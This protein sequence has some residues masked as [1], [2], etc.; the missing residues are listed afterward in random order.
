MYYLETNALYQLHSQITANPEKIEVCCTSLLAIEEILAGIT[1]EE[2]CRRKTIA[3]NIAR[4]GI[5]I[6]W[7]TPREIITR[8]FEIVDID[9]SKYRALIQQVYS[10]IGKSSSYANLLILLQQTPANASIEQLK[11]DEVQI[12]RAHV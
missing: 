12:G 1:P 8:S 7:D 11:N 4:S 2:Y 5:V 10:A 3:I 6:D 9:D